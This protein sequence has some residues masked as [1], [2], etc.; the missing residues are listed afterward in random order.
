MLTG[1]NLKLDTVVKIW[2]NPDTTQ[3]NFSYGTESSSTQEQPLA[4]H[5]GSCLFTSKGPGS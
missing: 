4:I 5:L 1:Q 2:H 3:T